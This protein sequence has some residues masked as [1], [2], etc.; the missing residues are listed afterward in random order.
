MLVHA[1]FPSRCKLLLSEVNNLDGRFNFKRKN[2]GNRM[3]TKATRGGRATAGSCRRAASPVLRQPAADERRWRP[4][5][6]T[7]SDVFLPSFN[8]PYIFF[9]LATTCVVSSFRMNKWNSSSK[10]CDASVAAS[11][12]FHAGVHGAVCFLLLRRDVVDCCRI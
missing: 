3:V 1:R 7:L 4:K 8:L 11:C 5:E 12:R 6:K 9:I 2:K 10:F